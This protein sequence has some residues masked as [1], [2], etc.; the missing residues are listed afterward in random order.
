VAAGAGVSLTTLKR[1]ESTWGDAHYWP[2]PVAPRPGPAGA[3]LDL[4]S[5]SLDLGATLI[6]IGALTNLALLEI[7]RPGSLTGMPVVATAGWFRSPARGLPDWG[8]ERRSE[9]SEHVN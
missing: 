1:F 7:R 3:A 9:V 6:A 2:E 8:D 4:L 5:Q